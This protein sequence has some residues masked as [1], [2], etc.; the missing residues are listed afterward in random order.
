MVSPATSFPARD[1]D[2]L[3]RRQRAREAQYFEKVRRAETS[4]AIQLRRI[5]RFVDDIVRQFEPGSAEA[6]VQIQQMLERY[7]ELLRPWALSAGQRM[8]V[9]VARRDEQAWFKASQAVGR[10]LRREIRETP[11][12]NQVRRLLED[13]VLLITSI[14]LDA[15]ERVQQLT[16]EYLSGGRRYAELVPMIQQTGQ[17]TINR[18]TLIARTETAKAASALTQARA[19][20]VGAEAYVWRTARDRDVRAA[21]KRLEGTIHRWDTPP[22]AEE[23]GQRHH[24]GEFP[25]CFTGET[26]LGPRDGVV[27]VLR[28]FYRGPLVVLRVGE[29]LLRVTPNHPVLTTRGWI[30][31]GVLEVGDNLIQMLP[32]SRQTIIKDYVDDRYSSFEEVFE[33][34]V[35]NGRSC[36]SFFVDNLYG[37]RVIDNKVDVVRADEDLPFSAY[38][39]ILKSFGNNMVSS[40][41]A[42]L[43]SAG[44]GGV[45]PE[46]FQPGASGGLDTK[47]A[48]VGGLSFGDKSIGSSLGSFDTM[49]LD[50]SVNDASVDLV[51]DAESE[52]ALAEFIPASDNL[53]W[54]VRPS[55]VGVSGRVIQEYSGHVY[56][57]QTLEG[58]YSV[59]PTQIVVK[60]CRC[61]AEPILPAVIE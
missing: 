20:Y 48:L 26:L 49:L 52:G 39:G 16:R 59:T 19:R 33:S 36:H 55:V 56:T 3:T 25:N 37:D 17:V 53:F 4:Y 58:F 38:A 24:P 46:I 51:F 6:A 10:E 42:R 7:A 32:Q 60:N 9:E 11:I 45:L 2:R 61:Y 35:S 28:S 13:Q 50:Y 43:S 22:I 29:S 44:V 15:A 40:T 41:Y 47:V 23:G 8:I 57:L 5:A 27:A 30:R 34:L 14:P 12:G 21:H 1:A 54:E 31:A 18:A